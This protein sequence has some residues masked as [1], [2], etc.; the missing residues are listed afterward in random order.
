MA[1]ILQSYIDENITI[2]RFG[3]DEFLC[4]FL[5]KSKE[6][7]SYYLTEI[8][9]A[10]EKLPQKLHISAG[11]TCADTNCI[12]SLKEMIHHADTALYQAKNSGKNQFMEYAEQEA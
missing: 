5:N 8:F 4:M 7:I 1:D 2:Y 3:G 10:L 6:D 9:M 12:P 11:Y